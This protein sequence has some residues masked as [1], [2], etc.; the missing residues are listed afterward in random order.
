[1]RAPGLLYR[2]ARQAISMDDGL[3]CY[4]LMLPAIG[5]FKITGKHNLCYQCFLSLAKLLSSSEAVAKALIGN[6]TMSLKGRPFHNIGVDEGL[7]DLQGLTKQATGTRWHPAKAMVHTGCGF[8]LQ[9]VRE[10]LSTLTLGGG[11][12]DEATSGRHVKEAHAD[13]YA[14]A[15][16][17]RPMQLFAFNAANP[18]AFKDLNVCKNR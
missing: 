4:T 1:M 2:I 3:M 18:R 8:F 11:D 16:N 7:E 12:G 15:N 5:I 17:L 13:T 14:V 6:I 10:N 9:A